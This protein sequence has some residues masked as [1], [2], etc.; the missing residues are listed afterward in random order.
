M[1]CTA[2]GK[3]LGFWTKVGVKSETGIC[4]GCHE[5]AVTRLGVLARSASNAP[6][7]THQYAQGWLT[8]FQEIARKYNIP[9]SEALPL[10]YTLLNNILELVETR[11]EIPH[12][13][14]TFVAALAEKYSIDQSSPDQI[15]NAIFRIG[16]RETIQNW[17]R[18]EAP[19]VQ[20]R[21]VA[22]QNGEVCRWEESALL[23][24]QRVQR[25]YE[26]A[27]GSVSVPLGIVKGMRVR[28]GGFK[29]YPVDETTLEDGGAG[30]LHITNQRICFV[31]SQHSVAI[32]FKKMISLQGFETGFRI[33]TS[34]EKKPG[35]FIVRNPELS[36]HLVNLASSGQAEEQVP[37]KRRQKLL[38]IP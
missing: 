6:N 21:G 27:Y 7:W 37:R 32:P 2:C 17:E 19:T 22:L 1:N 25:H 18:G 23:R 5:Q 26:G 34:N 3:E 36:L 38:S 24:I 35:I 4:K 15:K 11:D 8:Q 30:A 20:C 13:D 31:G 10:W 28:V 9:A 12:S 33:E 16:T 14:L 29:G